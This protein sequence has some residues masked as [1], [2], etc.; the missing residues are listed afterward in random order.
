MDKLKRDRQVCRWYL[1]CT[2]CYMGRVFSSCISHWHNCQ[3]LKHGVNLLAGQ[4]ASGNLLPKP[5]PTHNARVIDSFYMAVVDIHCRATTLLSKHIET[6]WLPFFA[7][8]Q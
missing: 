8:N 6:Y 2:K 1:G 4:G 7:W 3:A 5:S